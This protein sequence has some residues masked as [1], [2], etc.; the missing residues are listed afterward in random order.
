M[1]PERSGKRRRYLLPRPGDGWRSTIRCSPTSRCKII[2]DSKSIGTNR[3]WIIGILKSNSLKTRQRLARTLSTL[4]SMHCQV[5]VHGNKARTTQRKIFLVGNLSKSGIRL[6][7]YSEKEIRGIGVCR[8]HT[9]A[10][11]T[12]Q[13]QAQGQRRN[14]LLKVA[15]RPS[16]LS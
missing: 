13:P 1:A 2:E 9:K 16:S 10:A 15:N 11:T 6:K 4:V 8:N 5:L 7:I 14:L 3:L 12:Y